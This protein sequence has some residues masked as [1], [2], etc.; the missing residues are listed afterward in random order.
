M[1]DGKTR[2]KKRGKEAKFEAIMTK[3]FSK[4]L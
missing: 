1:C 3:K 2:R 4:I